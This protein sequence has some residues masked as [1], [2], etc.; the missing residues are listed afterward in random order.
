MSLSMASCTTCSLSASSADVASSNNKIRGFTNKA[1]A[2][3]SLCFCPPESLMPRSPT[4]VA[5]FSGNPSTKSCAFAFLHASTTS[6]SV[7]PLFSPYTMLS[8][9]D[10]PKS[11]GSCKTRAMLSWSHN[12]SRSL[13]STPSIIICPPSAS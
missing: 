4:I 9:T 8:F 12:G 3:A 7:T 1:R 10:M 13:M 6:S 5:Y 2:I 11:T